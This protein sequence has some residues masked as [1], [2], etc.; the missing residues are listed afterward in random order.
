MRLR[1]DPSAK[2]EGPISH[3]SEEPTRHPSEASSSSQQRPSDQ[4][5][6]RT[7]KAAER[8]TSPSPPRSPSNPPRHSAPSRRLTAVSPLISRWYEKEKED[9]YTHPSSHP[10][11][12][13]DPFIP[14]LDVMTVTRP[15]CCPV[16]CA[17]PR[18]VCVRTALELLAGSCW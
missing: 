2:C 1:F 8:R 14:T 5:E 10:H 18:V 16:T 13:L 4:S 15:C 12:T 11:S 17:Q 7:V 3:P 6:R 9:I